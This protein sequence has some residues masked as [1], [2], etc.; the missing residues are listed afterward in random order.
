M[1]YI[2]QLIKALPTMLGVLYELKKINK[3]REKQE[4]EKKSEK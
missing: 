1:F 2:I 3:E 4:S